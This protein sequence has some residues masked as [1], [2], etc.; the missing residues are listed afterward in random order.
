MEMMRWMREWLLLIKAH[1]KWAEAKP[2]FKTGDIV[3]AISPD[4]PGAHWPLGRVL[5]VVPGQDGHI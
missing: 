2:N 3:L 1:Q 4:C 5:E